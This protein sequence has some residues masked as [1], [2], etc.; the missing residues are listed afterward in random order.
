[1]IDKKARVMLAK[2]GRMTFLTP[3]EILA[4]LKSVY[5]PVARDWTMV[6]FAY[7]KQALAGTN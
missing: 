7:P 6:L 3:D 4:V 2:R 5:E 1:V